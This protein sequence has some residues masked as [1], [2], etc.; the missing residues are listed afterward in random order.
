MNKR[1]LVAAIMLIGVGII[2][3]VVLVSN[4]GTGGMGSLFAG[5][6]KDIGTKDYTL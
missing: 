3:G 6:V 5:G 2:F 1:S 4:F